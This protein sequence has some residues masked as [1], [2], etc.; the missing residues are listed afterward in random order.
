[1]FSQALTG[2]NE[3]FDLPR[4]VLITSDPSPGV[5]GASKDKNK[6]TFRTLHK[7]NFHGNKANLFAFNV[8]HACMI[9]KWAK[10]HSC[11]TVGFVV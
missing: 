10:W 6:T 1:M 7:L 11:F 5:I 8:Y 3:D 4:T 9:Q 2:M